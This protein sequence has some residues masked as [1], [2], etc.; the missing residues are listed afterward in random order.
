MPATSCNERR[1]VTTRMPASLR[2]TLLAGLAILALVGVLVVDDYGVS[3]D[4]PAK[5]RLAAETVAYVLDGAPELLV[6]W[7]RNDGV[8]FETFLL[9]LARALGLEDS[10]D[11]LLGH[12][13]ASH[14]FFLFAGLVCAVL[15][16]RITGSRALA[17]LAMLVFVL[18]PRIYAHSFV[19]SK[20]V[21]HLSMFMIV[22]FLVH[23]AFD[24]DKKLT[25]VACGLGIGLLVNMRVMGAIMLVAVA[26]MRCIDYWRARGG[27]EK[28]HAAIT[29]G[30]CLL[31]AVVASYATWPYLWADPVT[32]MAEA[33]AW[34]LKSQELHNLFLGD[35]LHVDDTPRNYFPVWAGVTT[36]PVILLLGLAGIVF[37]ARRCWNAPA[38]AVRN[39]PLRF[40]CLCASLFAGLAVAV[41]ATGVKLHD[42][43][44]LLFFLHAPFA[45][46][47]VLGLRG[48]L[49]VARKK[50]LM[51][52]TWGSVALGVGSTSAAMV[53]IHP[54]ENV[55]FNILA[56]R[57]TP[58]RLRMQYDLDYWATSY[59]EALEHLVE[60][61]PVGPIHVYS[62][63]DKLLLMNRD[64]LPAA[65]RQ[66][67][68]VG[69]SVAAGFYVTNHRE[70]YVNGSAAKTIFAPAV[71]TRQVY[72]NT[73][74]TI[75]ETDLSLVPDMRA[76]AY[77]AAYEDA[78][79]G[80]PAARSGFDVFLNG[81]ELS[82]AKQ[83]CGPGD[84]RTP[85]TLRVL[86]PGAAVAPEFA[87]D[88]RR[89]RADRAALRSVGT[90]A[91]APAE[92]WR[93]LDFYFGAHGVVVDGACW[94]KIRLPHPVARVHVGQE[95]RDGTV[96]WQTDFPV[97]VR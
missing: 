85:F 26:G 9:L 55:Y 61:H 40:E 48:A 37:T 10:R 79:A 51:V 70:H 73:I 19:N 96:S 22:L 82:F 5:H 27:E 29:T 1:R 53:E 60:R 52:L 63:N 23:R 28:R 59:R 31:A 95:S 90:I 72:G 97:A 25:F 66:R 4:A 42:G 75:A 83:E 93:T 49:A 64:I 17:C 34:A 74:M 11:V 76:H 8:V 80:P 13:L 46:L 89:P 65:Q 54:Y 87:Q 33:F 71:Y 16:Y 88:G 24:K 14:F 38:E 58:Q 92:G 91:S 57:R 3:W 43:W 78:V 18:H 30:L 50:W 45:V 44:R 35:V 39:S 86:P 56:D 77:R 62:Y 69:S 32:R 41:I 67:I 94:A 7:N 21:P 47:A 20:D 81:L 68:V 12:H 84:M 15:A 6:S 2:A 36:P